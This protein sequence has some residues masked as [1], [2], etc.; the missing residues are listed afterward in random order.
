M[1]SFVAIFRK[2]HQLVKGNKTFQKNYGNFYGK[3]CFFGF[4]RVLVYREKSFIASTVSE[5]PL[6]IFAF[7]SAL[8]K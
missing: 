6:T 1:S 3:F 4:S 7:I 2:K 5:Y 8:P